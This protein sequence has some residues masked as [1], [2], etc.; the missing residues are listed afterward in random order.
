MDTIVRVSETNEDVI[1]DIYGDDAENIKEVIALLINRSPETRLSDILGILLIRGLIIE[2]K[3]REHIWT[4]KL[5]K[6][7]CGTLSTFNGCP[8]RYIKVGKEK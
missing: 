4:S 3:V 1:F 7:S 2:G 6:I 8:N 5:A